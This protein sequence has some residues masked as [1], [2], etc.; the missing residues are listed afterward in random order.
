MLSVSKSYSVFRLSPE[1]SHFSPAP[2]LPPSSTAVASSAPIVYSPHNRQGD[3]VKISVT[4]CHPSVHNP[5]VAPV[6]LNVLTAPEKAWLSLAPV[7]LFTSPAASLLSPQPMPATSPPVTYQSPALGP[8]HWL[9]LP[10]GSL[11]SDTHEPSSFTSFRSLPS[12]PLVGDY[13]PLTLHVKGTTLPCL[14]SFPIILPTIRRTLVHVCLVSHL[15]SLLR[16]EL[17]WSRHGLF[18][19]RL[20]PQHLAHSPK[21]C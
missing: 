12:C 2:L 10:P 16:C 9:P 8:S 1:P 13:S 3:P 21:A 6:S 11:L 18:R 19:S 20:Y 5:L 15:P 17:L 14:I 4:A 7:T